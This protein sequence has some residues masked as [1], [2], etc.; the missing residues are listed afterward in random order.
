[1]TA[2]V[3]ANQVDMIEETLTQAGET[4]YRLG[5]IVPRESEPGILIDG[6]AT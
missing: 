1:M 3:G 6:I 4:V 5:R 2:V